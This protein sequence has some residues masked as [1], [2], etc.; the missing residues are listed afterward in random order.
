[1]TT[2]TNGRT[3][4]WRNCTARF[5]RALGLDPELVVVEAEVL[6]LAVGKGKAN[7]VEEEKAERPAEGP[8]IRR[9]MLQSSQECCCR[10]RTRIR[11]DPSNLSAVILDILPY[12]K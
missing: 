7:R 10:T 6:L 3:N 9:L 4:S 5:S 1:M 11:C 2:S 12:T 8:A